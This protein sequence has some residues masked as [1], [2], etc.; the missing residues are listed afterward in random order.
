[1][2]TAQNITFWHKGVTDLDTA[3]NTKKNLFAFHIA[4]ICSFDS[5]VPDR[6][7]TV[8]NAEI[9]GLESRHFVNVK[10]MSILNK[11]N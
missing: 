8:D 6:S 2:Y 11:F 10:T 5:A 9:F 7:S 3:H 1:M 4:K